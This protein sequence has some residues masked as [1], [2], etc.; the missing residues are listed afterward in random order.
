MDEGNQGSIVS[1]RKCVGG[2]KYIACFFV[3]LS[4]YSEE[5]QI[6]HR[7]RRLFRGHIRG[8]ESVYIA[9][10]LFSPSIKMPSCAVGVTVPKGKIR[11]FGRI[12]GRQMSS[13]S[14]KLLV[15]LILGSAGRA[16]G[17]ADFPT[18]LGI[19]KMYELMAKNEGEDLHFDLARKLQ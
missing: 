12:A 14:H 8:Q 6:E 1:E 15:D 4:T 10:Q 9:V 18:S 17:M 2:P 19:L 11:I 7:F 5:R 13:S 3:Y 16:D